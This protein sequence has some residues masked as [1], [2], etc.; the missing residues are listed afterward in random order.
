MDRPDKLNPDE[1]KAEILPLRK[2]CP[3]ASC[4]LADRKFEAET[5]K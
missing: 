2:V 1:K 5:K 3:Y 4:N